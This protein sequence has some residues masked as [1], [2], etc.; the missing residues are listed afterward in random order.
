MAE[1]LVA[2]FQSYLKYNDFIDALKGFV[3]GSEHRP[4][5]QLIYLVGKRDEGLFGYATNGYILSK[6]KA[7]NCVVDEDFTG[8][9]SVPRIR[10][11]K[12]DILVQL[13]QDEESKEMRIQMGYGISLRTKFPGNTEFDYEGVLAQVRPENNGGNTI[14]VNRTFLKTA[15]QSLYTRADDRG[16]VVM[17]VPDRATDA[18]HLRKG[19]N[20]RMVLPMRM[21]RV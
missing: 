12:E 2:V 5:F 11:T 13:F 3:G 8:Y 18:I 15:I 7:E 20:E 21:H 9:I 6:Q 4:T 14:G 17:T 1:K 19:E 16:P 10:A